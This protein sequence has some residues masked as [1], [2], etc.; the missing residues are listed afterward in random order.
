MGY[1][2]DLQ[3]GALHYD[4]ASHVKMCSDMKEAA[5]LFVR[6]VDGAIHQAS[7]CAGSGPRV[8]MVL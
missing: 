3:V 1:L 8:E 7:I 6:V 5:L 4:E 2:L